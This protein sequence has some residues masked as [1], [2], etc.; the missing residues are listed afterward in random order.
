VAVFEFEDLTV[1]WEHRMFGGNQAEKGESVG[2]L[3]L[4]DRGTFHM[5]WQQGA[6]FYPIGGRK[7]PVKFPPRLNKPDDQNIKELWR[8]FLQAIQSGKRP[9]SDVEDVCNSTNI[10][11]LGMLSYKL[12][13]GIRWDGD[14]GV[15]LNDPEANQLLQRKYRSPW[16]YPEVT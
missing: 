6:V 4:W 12:G 11:L 3:L 15:I 14:R 16:I 8:D 10:S 9:V 13:R 1:S 7:E 2:L 5:G